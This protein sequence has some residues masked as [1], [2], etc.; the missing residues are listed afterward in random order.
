M[1]TFAFGKSSKPELAAPAVKAVSPAAGVAAKTG[2]EN[3]LLPGTMLSGVSSEVIQI[4][5]S[6]ISPEELADLKRM[7]VDPNGPIPV[8]LPEMIA[9][10]KEAAEHDMRNPA[11]GISPDTPA[12]KVETKDI[13]E[14]SSETQS[15]LRNKLAEIMSGA[16]AA[17]TSSAE[18]DDSQLQIENDIDR[19]RLNEATKKAAA[20]VAPDK[21][22]PASVQAVSS[23]SGHLPGIKHCPHCKWD[24]S[25]DSKIEA[26]DKDK[27]TYVIATIGGVSFVKSYELFGGRASAEFRGSLFGELDECYRQTAMDMVARGGTV[28]YEDFV[29]TFKLY[30]LISQ[31][32]RLDLA[33]NVMTFPEK[34]SEWEFDDQSKDKTRLQRIL[35][36]VSGEAIKS[37]TVMRVLIRLND[38]FNSLLRKLE[39]M[40]DDADFWNPTAR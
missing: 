12:L 4:D 18:V 38:E 16:V 2:K 3:P 11:L 5:P 19:F 29:D 13:S 6:K 33:G 14:L 10:A 36:V 1:P 34:L 21:V 24:L 40:S 20:P 37:H 32:S 27:Q 8:S 35:A 7:G 26:T 39:D 15:M 25:K 22:S 28:A 17:S 31:L 23:D 30:R 9:R